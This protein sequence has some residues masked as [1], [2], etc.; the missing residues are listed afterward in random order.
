M[1]EMEAPQK[2]LTIDIGGSNIKAT[3]LNAD[4]DFV[5][6][7][8]KLPTPDPA[9]PGKVMDVIRQL[10][11][12]FIGFDHI[13]VG[14]PGFIK[15]GVVK[16]APN[17]GTLEWAEFNLEKNLELLLGKPVLAINDADLQAL[18]LVAGKG[19]EMVI[20]LGTGFGSAI[21]NNGV[22]IPHQ[23][24]AHH[25]VTKNKDYD[26]YIG[27]EE[28][29]RIGKK[30]WNKRM[31]RVIEILKVVINYDTL[32]ISGGNADK[33]NFKLDKNIIIIN[34]RD[35]IKGGAT[36]WKQKIKEMNSEQ[37]M[38]VEN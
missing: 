26:E 19:V 14:F 13:S 4:G 2:I 25:P 16:T 32:Y 31:Q 34:N 3:V 37:L 1:I 8:Q 20:T 33:L 15:N 9:T 38:H 36:L 10:A 23:E 28:L 24:I 21:L 22:L 27:E 12:N 7:Y 30:T 18:A 29:I 5:Q 35:G 17:L 11:D 6:D